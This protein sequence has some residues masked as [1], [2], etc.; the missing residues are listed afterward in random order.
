MSKSSS[1]PARIA[2]R[3]SKIRRTIRHSP[4]F[5]TELSTTAGGQPLK[6]WPP[7]GF[8]TG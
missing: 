1:F 2:R 8:I 7:G 5:G 3:G 6:H 4:D